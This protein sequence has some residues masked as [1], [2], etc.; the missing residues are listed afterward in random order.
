MEKGMVLNAFYKVQNSHML[1]K[2]MY[3]ICIEVVKIIQQMYNILL[4]L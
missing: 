1:I 3:Y 2:I 4:K